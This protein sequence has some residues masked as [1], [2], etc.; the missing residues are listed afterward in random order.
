MSELL[1][2]MALLAALTHGIR[3][4]SRAAG[5]RLGGLLLG[6]PSTT[7]VALAGCG[8]ASGIA[9]ATEMAEASLLG[10]V[11]A[12]TLPLAFAQAMAQ[13]HRLAWAVL[14]AVFAYVAVAWSAALLPDV[15]P[16][17]PLVMATVAI[18]AAIGCADR[19]A[20]PERRRRPEPRRIG[21]S[22][23]RCLV[24]RTA[25]PGLCL[26][27]VNAVRELGGIRSAG[28]FSTFPGMSLTVLIVTYLESSS[29]EA[30]RMARTLPSANLGMV[31]FIAGFRFSAPLVGLGWGTAIGYAMAAPILLAVGWRTQRRGPVLL[32]RRARVIWL[33]GR[34]SPRPFFSTRTHRSFATRHPGP[35]TA[36]RH[37]RSAPRRRLAPLVE[38]LG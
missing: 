5:P 28:L 16:V 32:P 15:G 22:R 8:Q 31:A 13:G 12:V 21:P 30:G 11:A 27:A 37:R 29:T 9:A 23:T 34:P 10:L 24:L 6:L 1:L 35:S 18:L 36:P 2:K 33:N 7:A 20:I 3:S 25:V 17:G 14:A 38:A 19:I 4:L 26:A